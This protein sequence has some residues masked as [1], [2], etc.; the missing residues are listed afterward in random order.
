ME[1]IQLFKVTA[2]FQFAQVTL[3]QTDGLRRDF[4]ELVIV[5]KLD[6]AVGLIRLPM[7]MRAYFKRSSENQV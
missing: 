6:R 4:N 1:S 7:G 3:A 2:S 5:D